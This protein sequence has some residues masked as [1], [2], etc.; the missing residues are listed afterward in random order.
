MSG[1]IESGPRWQRIVAIAAALVLAILFLRLFSPILLPFVAAAG[2]AYFL[3]PA[4]SALTRLRVPRSLGTAIMLLALIASVALAALL[5]YPLISAQIGLLSHQLPGMIDG[6]QKF[7]T[8]E[9]NSIQ[10]RFGHGFVSTKLQSLVSNEAGTIMGFAGTAARR[11]VGTGFVVINILTL[12]IITPIVAFYFL[13]DW[14]FF[15]AR[16]DSWLPR[17]HESV[18]RN[19]AQEISRILNAWLRGQAICCLF[20][21]VFYAIALSLAGLNLGLVIGLTAGLLSFIPYVGTIV[22]AVSSIVLALGQFNGIDHVIVV[23]VIFVV[24][25]LLNDYVVAPRFLGDR[26]GLSAVWVIFALFAGAET[27][28][29][30]GVLLAVPVTATLGVLARFW[31]RRYLQSSLYLDPPNPDV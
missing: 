14:P 28:G 17:S 20:L 10:Q 15:I 5:L 22:G 26:L 8:R 23:A 25:Q 29:F 1:Q 2:I 31:L 12:L 19:L 13:R 18:I 7:V 30:L 4:V 6:L 11:V 9:I 3:D 21:G 16:I 24:G 27:F